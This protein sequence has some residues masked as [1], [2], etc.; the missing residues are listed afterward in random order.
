MTYDEYPL[1]S[2]TKREIAM[3]A[4][5]RATTWTW[6]LVP[7]IASTGQRSCIAFEDIGWWS[8]A[9]IAGSMNGLRRHVAQT[10]WTNSSPR[11]MIHLALRYRR[12]PAKVAKQP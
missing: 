2:P 3:V 9:S 7:P 1:I 6:S 12:T 10:A 4:W 11:V 5:T 8:P